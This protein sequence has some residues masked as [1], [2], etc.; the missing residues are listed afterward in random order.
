MIEK[1]LTINDIDLY[2][3][4]VLVRNDFN[5]PMK[6]AIITDDERIVRALPTIRKIID[7]GGIAILCSHLGRP[8]GERNMEYSLRPVADML[9]DM[10]AQE[11]L[12]LD[13]CIGAEVEDAVNNAQTGDVILLENLR[14]HAGETKND[15]VF[16][17]QL[18]SFADVYV[19]DAFGTAH[20]THASNVGVAQLIEPA[21]AGLLMLEE[22]TVFGNI[23]SSPKRPFIC[24]IG[25]LKI[26]SKTSVIDN[27]LPNVNKMLLGG[28]LIFT[29]YKALGLEISPTTV[30]L[31]QELERFNKLISKMAKS[32][33]TLGR[34]SRIR[35]YILD[36]WCI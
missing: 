24:I 3:K 27:I 16:V 23:L 33:V 17:A 20:R 8:K 28:G 12:F 1:K 19:N 30:V 11:V 29:F 14:F 2:G 15:P 10:L 31:L 34:V 25:G 6:N 36:V 21:V 7:D 9:S 26:S 32:L 4:K 22:L 35:C 5:V 18:S 13:D